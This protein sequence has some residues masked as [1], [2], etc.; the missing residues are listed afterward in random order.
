MN[1]RKLAAIAIAAATALAVPACSSNGASDGE[2]VTVDFATLGPSSLLWTFYIARDQGFFEAEGVTINQIVTQNSSLLVQSVA[3]GSAMIGIGQSDNLIKAVDEGASLVAL[4]ATTA[5]NESRLIGAPGINDISELEGQRVA[6]GAVSGGTGDMLI[7]LMQAGG[8]D[9]G[10]YE[11]VAIPNS[12]DRI[13]GIQNQQLEGALLIAPYDSTALADGGIVLAV[14]EE[15]Y[16]GQMLVANKTW[17]DDNPDAA[18]RV[19]KAMVS[20][21]NWLFDPANREEAQKILGAATETEAQATSDAYD[22]LVLGSVFAKDMKVSLEGMQ[23]VINLGVQV[24][25]GELR[26]LDFETYVDES[27]L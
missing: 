25:G 14:Y 11:I 12:S 27:Y 8:L 3:S 15:P 6:A 4:G 23:N 26:E 16:V 10:T 1:V 24:H 22:F 21:A 5:K 19:T 17:A 9:Q 7:A 20:A 13:V 2:Y 18:K